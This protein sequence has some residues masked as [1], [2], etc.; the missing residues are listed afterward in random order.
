MITTEDIIEALQSRSKDELLKI[1][2]FLNK[3]LQQ[4]ANIDEDIFYFILN[5]LGEKP[6]SIA[7]F[8]R[9]PIGSLWK[10]SQEGFDEVVRQI[11]EGGDYKR[12]QIVA[13]KRFLVTMMLDHLRE[14]KKPIDVKTVCFAMGEF[15]KIYDRSFP[16]YRKNQLGPLIMS[17]L[18]SQS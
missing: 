9:G 7:K 5:E 8:S 1:Q 10:S 6:I 2:A 18:I 12:V 11:T 15:A 3:E 4:Y 13:L 16:G 14:K 17:K